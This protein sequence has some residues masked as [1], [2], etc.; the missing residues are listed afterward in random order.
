M[1]LVLEPWCMKCKRVLRHE[2]IGQ[3]VRGGTLCK[4]CAQTAAARPARMSQ[5]LREI[6]GEG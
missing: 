3:F 2:D 1:F 5:A 4:P 6:L